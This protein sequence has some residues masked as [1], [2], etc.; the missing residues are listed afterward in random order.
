[1]KHFLKARFADILAYLAREVVG[2][3]KPTVIMVTGSVG[4][5][6]TKDAVAAALSARYHLRAS[7]KSFNSEY[8]VPLTI[9]GEK[10][11]WASVFAWAKAIK[12]ALALLFLPNH[13]PNLLVLEVGADRPGDL[14]KILRIASPDVVVLTRLPE[15]PV[16]VEAYATPDAVREEEFSP[17]YLL[18]AGAPLIVPADDPYAVAMARRVPARTITY[19]E[20]AGADIRLSEIDFYTEGGRVAGMRAHIATEQGG[21]EMV[22]KGS[23]GRTQMLPMAAAVATALSLG[24]TLSEALAALESYEAPSGRG[25]IFVGKG[26]TTLIDDTY[27]A[28]PAAVEEALSTLK[29]FP[30]TKGHKGRKI[31]VLGDML[32]LGRYSVAEHERIGTLAGH[33]ADVVV[34][35]GIRARALAESARASHHAGCAFSYDNAREAAH[36][37]QDYIEPG[38]ILLVKGSQSIRM[39]R[40]VAA[41]LEDPADTTKLV[42]QDEEWKRR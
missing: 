26:E 10:N 24:A 8:G 11:P 4:K 41:L 14:A 34:T 9:F 12:A 2:K 16:H 13:Y 20:R 40:I 32:E 5:T 25:R 15:V 22:V 17:A 3:Y 19:G 29:H 33:S 21:G 39:E 28:S 36:A 31:A 38:D 1:M 30:Q 35:V 23:I 42:R 18:A 37:L 7:E 27:N 6:S